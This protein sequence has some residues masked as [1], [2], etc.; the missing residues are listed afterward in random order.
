MLTVTLRR[1]SVPVNPQTES[2][3]VFVPFAMTD[4]EIKEVSD[5][6]LDGV[7]T[8]DAIEQVTGYQPRDEQGS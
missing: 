2:V 4:K 7:R 3:P 1:Y 5:L 6:I 8:D